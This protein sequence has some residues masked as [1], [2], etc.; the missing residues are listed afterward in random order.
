MQPNEDQAAVVEDQASAVDEKVRAVTCTTWSPDQVPDAIASLV[1]ASIADNTRRAYR[2]DLA[3]FIT[4]AGH[5]PHFK[6]VA[7]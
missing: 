7:R 6:L 2:S 1:E 4:W 3:T 5:A